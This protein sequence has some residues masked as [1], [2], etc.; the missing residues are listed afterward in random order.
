MNVMD[1]PAQM[2][3]DEAVIDTA[4]VTGVVTAM[5][6]A[7]LVAV[8]EVTQVKLEVKTQVTISPFANEVEL[9]VALL[10]PTFDPFI[11]H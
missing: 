9:K 4:G 5:V 8:A 1:V 3:V 7:L 2:V 10:V 6:N 11:F